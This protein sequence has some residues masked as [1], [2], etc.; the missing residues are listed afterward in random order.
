MGTKT[1]RKPAG[2]GGDRYLALVRELPLRPLRSEKELDRAIAM[3][4]SLLDRGGLAPDEED[5]LDVLSDLV[6]KY[7]DEHHPMP[8]VSGAEMLRYLIEIREVNQTK[9]AKAT[10]IAESTLSEILT[11]KR[12]LNVKHIPALARYFRVNP[13]VLV[14][15]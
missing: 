7:E 8:P 11:G 1:E 4:D 5:Y 3:I 15:D 13:G 2:P 14:S 9:V 12:A 10:G 6:E